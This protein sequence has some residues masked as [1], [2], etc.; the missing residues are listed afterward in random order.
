MKRYINP[1]LTDPFASSGFMGVMDR[2]EERERELAI[3]TEAGL[4]VSGTRMLAS[5]DV[6]Y[7]Q[8]DNG[9]G[10]GVQ[11]GTSQ[12]PA[13]SVGDSERPFEMAIMH[14]ADLTLCYASPISA[15]VICPLDADGVLRTLDEIRALLADSDCTHVTR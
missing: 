4:D 2:S 14:G 15:D 7:Y 10:A 1:N 5:C 6:A 12:H 9:F 11:L 3:L 13:C 8:F